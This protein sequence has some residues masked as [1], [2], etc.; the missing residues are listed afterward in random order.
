[1]L[2]SFD[3]V[4]E[5]RW[6]Y[7]NFIYKEGRRIEQL[8][9]RLLELIVLGKEE[10]ELKKL[11]SQVFFEQ[12]KEEV[13]AFP[14]G[15]YNL[16]IHI[17]YVQ[18]ELWIEKTLLMTA[19]LNVIDNACKASCPGGDVYVTGQIRTGD[20]IIQVV[21]CGKGIPEDELSKIAE[22]FYMVDKARSRKQGG[23]GLGLSLCRRIMELHGGSMQIQS[24]GLSL[25]DIADTYTDSE[26]P[27]LIWCTIG[28]QPTRKGME[29]YLEDG[30]LYTWKAPEH[31]MV[32]CGYDDKNYYFLDSLEVGAIVAYT[33]EVAQTRFEEMGCHALVIYKE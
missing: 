12:L 6:E 17:K 5:K 22:P 26:I 20:Y 28:M 1:M 15:K 18:E 11:P 10:Y 24:S 14:G 16:Q 27:V 4:P 9:L 33:K 23:A 25:S 32:L 19:V 3:L 29:Y 30:S 7:S 21:D 8:S 13:H 31:C 2:R